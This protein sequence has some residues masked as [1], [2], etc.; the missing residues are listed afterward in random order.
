ME[1]A[2]SGSRVG[3]TKRP[4]ASKYWSFT[5]NNF[6]DVAPLK[7]KLEEVCVWAVFQEETGES[8][9]KHLQGTL[10]LRVKGR[11][12]EIFGIKEIHWE[13]TRHVNESAEYCTKDE[14]RTGERW[15][16]GPVPSK[17]LLKYRK[18]GWYQWQQEVL[19]LL[20]E[21]PDDRKVIWV[22]DPEGCSGKSTL[23][24]YLVIE[25]NALVVSGTASDIF[26][27]ISTATNTEI[28]IFDVPRSSFGHISY[29]AIE[30]IK[31]GLF[32]SGKYESKMHVFN[33]PHL[34]VMANEMPEEGQL[35]SDRYH[36]IRGV[37]ST[38]P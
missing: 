31:N 33:P 3:N 16:F 5:W 17:K 7:R 10:S 6:G 9:T 37:H 13:K 29:K 24:R 20:K 2:P 25:R 23:C 32:F 36:I 34:V 21:D 4:S 27:A 1:L 15:S 19:D 18:D 35:T 28:V 12:K 26:Y 30:C 8:G 14:T 22:F 11:P 38:N